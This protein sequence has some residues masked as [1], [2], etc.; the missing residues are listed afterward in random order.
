MNLTQEIL[1]LRKAFSGRFLHW[2]CSWLSAVRRVLTGARAIVMLFQRGTVR[3][4]W[5][6]S[7]GPVDVAWDAVS[8]LWA[9]DDPEQGLFCLERVERRGSDGR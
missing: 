7:G 6:W 5:T 3:R 4:V 1:L 9:V 8:I 2:A